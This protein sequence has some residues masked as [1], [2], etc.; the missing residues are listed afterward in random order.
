MSGNQGEEDPST[1]V[2]SDNYSRTPAG[3]ENLPAML[4]ESGEEDLTFPKGN[5]YPLNSRRLVA[6]QL[7]RL[8]GILGLPTSSSLA[9]T[10]QLIEGKLLE[11]GCEPKNV[12]VIE[13]DEDARLYLVT[14]DG[15]ISEESAEV[16]HCYYLRC[17]SSIGHY[18]VSSKCRGFSVNFEHTHH[19]RI[20]CS[21]WF[22][23]S[24]QGT[25][26]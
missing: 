24:S 5:V 9:S 11:M 18:F 13:S 2:D 23:F 19:S 25:S 26:G 1:L 22:G 15:V 14:D 21:S 4:E 17:L 12:Q 6:S 3:E 10:R 16:I 7:H 20:K 8:A